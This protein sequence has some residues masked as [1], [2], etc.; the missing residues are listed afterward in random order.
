LGG[1]TRADPEGPDPPPPPFLADQKFI[2][3]ETL[4]KIINGKSK[5]Q[6]LLIERIL[7][8]EKSAPYVCT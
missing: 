7:L 4:K 1:I 5:R 3:E 2:F 6:K 8:S